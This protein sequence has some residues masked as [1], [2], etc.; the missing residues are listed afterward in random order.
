MDVTHKIIIVLLIILILLIVYKKQENAGSIGATA[1]SAEAVQNIA[2]VY[3][4]TSGTAN[5]N[6]INVTGKL[7]MN[8]LGFVFWTQNLNGVGGINVEA[9]D[10]SG[11]TYPGDKWVLYA[12]GWGAFNIG[13]C[14]TNIQD[15]K[16]HI[17]FW[18]VHEG[19]NNV[20][21][22]AIPRGYFSTVYA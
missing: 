17:N 12:G 1:Y 9:R 18:S 5:F 15:N 13:Q 22:L 6:N 19:G 21:I 7:N 16:W 3:S 4:D 14:I 10:P 20:Q 8:N 11:N 2:K